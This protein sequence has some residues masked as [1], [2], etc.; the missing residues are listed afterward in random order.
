[1]AMR[2]LIVLGVV[3]IA[4]L[5][6][7]A[8]GDSETIADPTLPQPTVPLQPTI[9]PLQATAT[10]S[11]YAPTVVGWPP[12]APNEDSNG[13]PEPPFYNAAN[14]SVNQQ[15]YQSDAV[16]RARLISD[17]NNLLRFQ[18][19]EYLKGT[20]P[21]E[22]TIRALPGRD[23]SHDDRDAILFL[24]ATAEASGA[25]G[26]RFEFTESI[27]KT[28]S[29]GFA[30]G[31]EINRQDRAWM[32]SAGSGGATGNSDDAQFDPGAPAPGRMHEEPITVAAIKTAIAWMAADNS[33][34]Y[35][36][37]IFRAVTNEA[38]YRSYVAYYG[39]ERNV[40]Y[41]HHIASGLP[42]G[43]VLYAGTDPSGPR[44]GRYWTEGNDA[45]LFSFAYVDTDTEPTN[46]YRAPFT[47]KRPLTAGTYSVTIRGING[48]FLPCEYT[49]V[50]DGVID[51][52]ITVTAPT[53]V[54]HEA[55]FDPVALTSG[56]GVDGADGV[57]EPAE[58][59]VG[60]TSTSVTGLKWESGKVVLSLSTHVSL[61][62]YR[63]EFIELDGSVG[64][65]LEVDDASVDAGAGTLTWGVSGQ[66]WEDGDLLML[67]IVVG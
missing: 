9:A 38:R 33:A 4:L 31:H 57:L 2:G 54:V 55:F 27:Y 64:L 66:P 21:S 8:C 6:I 60:E 29:G 56:V 58:F 39:T 15:I 19:V 52:T 14:P 16:V 32:P 46:G 53:D 50:W 12:D 18:V 25:S 35:R 51:Y 22:V 36:R 67:R 11:L 45:E 63:L 24:K 40:D 59:S 43:Y 49:P 30:S 17:T 42:A 34:V 61:E 62:G 20:G 65:S 7:M 10:P 47:T 28:Y 41:E 5:A 44:Y 26:A 48:E 23:T 13:F 1:M 3:G 37:C